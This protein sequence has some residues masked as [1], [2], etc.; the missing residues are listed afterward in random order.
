MNSIL[1]E[2]Y[3]NEIVSDVQLP[4][5]SVRKKRVIAVAY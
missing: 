4:S 3:L 1:K 5:L 2:R